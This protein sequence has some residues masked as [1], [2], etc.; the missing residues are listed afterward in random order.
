VDC[1]N[2]SDGLDG[3]GLAIDFPCGPAQFTN[4]GFFDRSESD[5][6]PN[7]TLRFKPTGNAMYYLTYGEG[8]KS[9]GFQFP[10]YV[11]QAALT[12]DLV[13][14][15]NESTTHYEL[16][17]KNTL[18]GGRV[19][20]NWAAWS[21]DFEDVQVS[22]LDPLTIIQNVN[23]AAQAN[24]TGIEGDITWRIQKHTT[25]AAAVAFTDAEFEEFSTAPCYDGQTAAQGCLPFTFADGTV[26][27]VQDL[28]GTPLAHAPEVQF[29]IRLE[30]DGF[31]AFGGLEYGY[32]LFY[33]WQDDSH[34]KL[35]N[36]PL[37][38]QE[39]FGK[40]NASIRLGP[41]DGSWLLALIGK[42]LTDELTANSGDSTAAIGQSGDIGPTPN[43]KFPEPG[44][45]VA[46]QATYRF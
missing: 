43:F 39:A 23:N 35:A 15:D 27:N 33:Y 25:L 6:N 8:F 3:V 11:P 4:S 26:A 2:V 5:F 1:P 30:G 32:S 28:A 21:T 16:G 42:N 14:Y 20:L 7:A 44:R 19:Q 46:L 18:A 24:S 40:I 29:N 31:E 38:S 13:E 34:F 36:D 17:G 41:T 12:R 37:D 10:T 22:S 45:Q 9:G